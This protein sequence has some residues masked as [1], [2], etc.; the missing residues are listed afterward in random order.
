[1]EGKSK[2]LLNI[3]KGKNKTKTV[4]AN[5][6]V[7]S[8]KEVVK[9]LSPDEERNLKAKKRVEELLQDIPL[10]HTG[11]TVKS[12]SDDLL[13]MD[14]DN[15]NESKGSEWLSEQVA[16]LTS[17]NETLQQE[18]DQAVEDYRKIFSEIQNIKG[19]NYQIDNNHFSNDVINIQSND[20]I[21]ETVIRLFSELQANY[22]AMMNP[23]TG[24]SDLVIYPLAFIN[25]L[26]MFF[27]F[28]EYEKKL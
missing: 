26:I 22:V 16:L 21:K 2:K 23:Q 13:E 8:N 10:N 7:K 19:G 4:P 15:S 24:K 28:L 12:K 20:A 1:M 14:I 11:E 18:R 9:P 17:L 27:P 3:A 5:I 6:K 25:R